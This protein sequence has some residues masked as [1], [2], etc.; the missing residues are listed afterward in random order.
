M[1]SDFIKLN[2]EQYRQFT[3]WIEHNSQELYE[4]KTAYECRWG[5]D[6]DFYVRLLDE[7]FV[8][9]EDIMLDMGRES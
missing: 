5:K 6:E 8:S 2:K 4:N 3:D 9:L 7:S 1:E